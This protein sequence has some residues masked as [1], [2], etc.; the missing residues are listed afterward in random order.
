MNHHLESLGWTLMH[1]CWQAGAIA[2][3]YWLADTALSKARS[4]TRYLLALA[5]MLLMLLG[6]VATFSYEETRGHSDLSFAADS[7]VPAAN[8]TI[9]SSISIDLVPLTGLSTAGSAERPAQRPDRCHRSAQGR[10]RH[11]LRAVRRQGRG[12][13]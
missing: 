4:Q 2:L 9:R 10:G 5:A 8:K 7:F 12:A 3:V 1:F 11:Q 6:A 13:P